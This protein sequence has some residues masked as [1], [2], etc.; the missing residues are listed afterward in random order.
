MKKRLIVPV[1]TLARDL[2]GRFYLSL[3]LLNSKPNEWEVIF[4]HF[5]KCGKYRKNN[6]ES[7]MGFI[8]LSSGMSDDISHY[9]RI[10]RDGG[11]Y[12]LMD[13]E[14]GVS[15]KYDLKYDPRSGVN[16][17]CVDYV[18]KVFFWGQ[19]ERDNWFKRHKQFR[20]VQAI[21][22]GNPRFDI[23]KKHFNSYFKKINEIDDSKPNYILVVFAFGNAN[24]MI[25][26]DLEARYWGSF[27]DGERFTRHWKPQL[28]FQ[29]KSFAKYA[30]GIVKL[31]EENRDEQFVIRPHPV[32]DIEVYN[33]LFHKFSN[34]EI[35]NTGP[36]QAWFPK[37]KLFIHNGC[38]TAIEAAVNGVTPICFAPY[39][40]EEV[41][42]TLTFDISHVIESQRELL[43]NFR[44]FAKSKQYQEKFAIDLSVLKKNLHN[45]DV[46]G[47]D[48]IVNELNDLD[49]NNR[50]DYKLDRVP[51][52][53]RVKD[54]IPKSVKD[55]LR[56]IT[57]YQGPTP[58]LLNRS[59]QEVVRELL[60]K[61]NRI[62]FP[63]IK[64]EDL[65]V[66]QQQLF[67]QNI[68][69]GQVKIEEIEEDLFLLN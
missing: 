49:F 12:C 42:Q 59:E 55:R 68:T 4:G 22:S 29:E 33:K 10:I 17:K 60:A 15:N 28:S 46:D 25:D 57:K 26:P 21:V 35:N 2:D 8:Y 18:E 7:H 34:V 45:I 51:F 32:E 67:E 61:R 54:S 6:P 65:V 11:K 24:G 53:Q 23:S 50:V 37:A 13:E 66:R 58:S 56:S 52:I 48:I 16:N 20:E 69:T 40:D 41:I 36:V 1:E 3:K 44:Q 5:K 9:R 47:T 30:D 62:K 19:H 31:V 64:L 63:G 14:G 38:T 27:K 43:E 39:I